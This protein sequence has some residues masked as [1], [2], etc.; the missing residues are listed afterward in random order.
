MQHLYHVAFLAPDCTHRVREQ[1]I[2]VEAGSDFEARERFYTVIP[3]GQITAVH[4]A[5]DWGPETVH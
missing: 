1:H 3:E 2:Y 4:L 5:G